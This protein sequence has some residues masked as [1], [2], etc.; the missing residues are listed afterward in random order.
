VLGCANGPHWQAFLA[1]LEQADPTGA[2]TV[3]TD[4][5]SDPTTASLP[6]RG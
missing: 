2:L 4:S 5:R 6:G 1:R 3:I